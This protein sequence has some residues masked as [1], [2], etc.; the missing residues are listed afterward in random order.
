MRIRSFYRAVQKIDSFANVTFLLASARGVREG[1]LWT[2]AGDDEP[3]RTSSLR[4]GLTFA[5]LSE[6]Q[7]GRD[8][9]FAL[10]SGTHVY[11]ADVQAL[12]DLAHAQHEPLGVTRLVGATATESRDITM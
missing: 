7:G 8:G 6:G 9:Y 2:S 10:L 11:H 3:C 4:L 5:V 1:A 12:E